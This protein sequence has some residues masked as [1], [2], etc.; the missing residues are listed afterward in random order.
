MYTS[1][2]EGDDDVS[3]FLAVFKLLVLLDSF[4]NLRYSSDIR[5]SRIHFLCI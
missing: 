2:L 5:E 4:S 1:L 3:Y